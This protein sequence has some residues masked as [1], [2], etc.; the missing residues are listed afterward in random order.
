MAGAIVYAPRDILAAPTFDWPEWTADRPVPG[1]RVEAEQPL[2]S[3]FAW[4]A[5]V[6]E[7]KQLVEKR[8]AMLQRLLAE[9]V[10]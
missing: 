1:S 7:A 5:T 4:G 3:V 6:L 9:G 8:S 2:C 10:S